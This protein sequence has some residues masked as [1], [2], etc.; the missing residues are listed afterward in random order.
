[1][2]LLK[3]KLRRDEEALREKLKALNELKDNED[4]NRLWSAA[5]KSENTIK[6]LI[7]EVQF[8]QFD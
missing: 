8:L 3:G 4:F 5:G 6:W 7:D 2:Q 1:M